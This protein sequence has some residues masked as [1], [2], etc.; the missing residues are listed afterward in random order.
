MSVQK[1]YI[2]TPIYYVN[3]EPH[4]GH[5][6]TTIVADVLA[7]Y[8]RW[9]GHQVFFLT[10]TDE[11][12]AK[13]AE[14]AAK[15]NMTPKQ[16]CDQNS[17]Y[18]REAWQL[19]NIA[20]DYFIRTTDAQHEQAVV[21]IFQ[22]LYA[23]GFLEEREYQGSYCVGCEKFLSERDLVDGLCP[24]HKRL[25]EVI[26]EK[27]WFF[28]LEDFLPQIRELI[29][30]DQIKIRPESRKNEVLGLIKEGVLTNFSVSRQKNKVSWGVTLP[31]DQDQ[32]SYVW[33][34]ALS[35]YITAIGY[36]SK[37]EE[38]NQW[39]PCEVHLMAQDILKFHAVYWPAILLALGLP[40]PQSEFIH[41]FFTINGQKMS[42][43]IGN[44]IKPKDLVS[45]FG[46]DATRYLLL[47]QFPF[48]QEADIREDLFTE[49]Y[50]SDL[51]N[52]LGNAVAR[53]T[54]LIEK[55]DIKIDWSKISLPDSQQWATER[56]KEL[57]EYRFDLVLNAINQR[58][59][60]NVDTYL[61]EKKPWKMSAGP[62]LD[63]VLGVVAVE[64]KLI[65]TWL[66]PFMPQVAQQ[67]LDIF[68]VEKIV[69]A[70]ILF[71]RLDL[72]S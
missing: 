9:Q 22:K 26:T 50:N 37:M 1:F 24:D 46:A 40:V 27:N 25:P 51:A 58:L 69:K 19:L 30:S 54:N 10:G 32:V 13:V 14:M 29:S 48:G 64:I 45:R 66:L 16:F 21:E 70:P 60:N 3:D 17:G 59:K 31:F 65:A 20:N 33:V 23:G 6:Y 57:A 44:V 62:E 49:R 35:N 63:Q 11:H 38:F 36:P 2:T 52:G 67:I 15:N 41:G 53:I 72:N 71:P 7:R 28:K 4:I 39:W 56:Q 34:D 5:A 55:N 43:T 18:F 8:H 47:S 68:A 12:G 61:S 42:K